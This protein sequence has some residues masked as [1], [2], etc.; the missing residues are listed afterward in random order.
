MVKKLSKYKELI[1]IMGLKITRFPTV[2]G[3]GTLSRITLDGKHICFG[4][5]QDWLN[6]LPF[7][8]CIPAGK[9]RL[10][11]Y[12]SPKYGSCFVFVNEDL[13]VHM[14]QTSDKTDRFAC[15]I[16]A[17]NYSRQLEGCLAP[18]SNI[19][20]NSS[21]DELMVGASVNARDTLF[22]VIRDNFIDEV[23]IEWQKDRFPSDYFDYG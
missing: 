2:E 10:L 1:N 9:Y 22:K 21:G 17:A 11:P 23:E 18:G 15:L 8:S 20:Y 6:N 14:H 7:K 19:S 4:I 12:N 3:N 16:H 5:E 13:K